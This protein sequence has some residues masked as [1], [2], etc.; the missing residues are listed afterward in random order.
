MNY[1]FETV[2]VLSLLGIPYNGYKDIKIQCPFC[3][4]QKKGKKLWIDVQKGIFHCWRATCPVGSG[5]IVTLY[6]KMNGDMAWKDAFREICQQLKI[7]DNNSTTKMRPPREVIAVPPPPTQLE[8]APIE[9]RHKAYQFLMAN[10]R[11]NLTQKHLD[12]LLSRGFTEEVAKLNYASVPNGENYALGDLCR[13]LQMQG[14]GL[15]GVPG[16]FKAKNQKWF[17]RQFKSGIMIPIISFHNMI[18][19]IQIR[20]DD[21]LLI[22]DE[23]TGEKEEKCVW[24]SSANKDSGTKA[25]VFIHYACDFQ[26]D[27]EREALVPVCKNGIFA[28]IEGPMKAD[29]FYELTGQPA[30]AVTGVKCL[31]F[32]PQELENLRTI[33][34]KAIFN[35][36]DMD[37]ETNE[38]VRA[39]MEKSK[40]IITEAG[41]QYSRPTWPTEVNGKKLLKGVDDYYAYV[42]KGIVPVIKNSLSE[43]DE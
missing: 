28:L 21:D 41:F 16:F 32:L 7:N 27:S 33:G 20:K 22:I 38:D 26:W 3:T 10:K 15:E 19:G 37:Y 30:I 36:Y 6:A 31:E 18:Q 42:K 29:L 5:N 9:K 4:E 2:E 14:I 8:M 17:F 35:L 34:V 43:N 11:C 39:A 1:P 24:V 23:E 13:D 40:K 25:R 12:N